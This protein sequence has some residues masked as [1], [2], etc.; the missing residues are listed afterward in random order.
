MKLFKT[1]VVV[2]L[3]AVMFSGAAFAQDAVG[4]STTISGSTTINVTDP[5]ITGG[6]ITGGS[7]IILPLYNPPVVRTWT[8]NILGTKYIYTYTTTTWANNN[9]LAQIAFSTK[10]YNRDNLLLGE[11]GY[12][13][14]FDNN[15]RPSQLFPFRRFADTYSYNAAKLLANKTHVY[16]L[17]NSRNRL[18]ETQDTRY[19]Y[20]YNTDNSI[21]EEVCIYKRTGSNGA[22]LDSWRSVTAYTYCANGD[23]Y[24]VY[25]FY[26]SDGKL[27][28]KMADI[29][30]ADGSGISKYKLFYDVDANGQ[31]TYTHVFADTA[32]PIVIMPNQPSPNEIPGVGGA[33]EIDPSVAITGIRDAANQPDDIRIDVN[34]DLYINTDKVYD[35]SHM[36][37]NVSNNLNMQS[38]QQNGYDIYVNG[39]L[40]IESTG[41]L[42]LRGLKIYATG[43]ITI[44]TAEDITVDSDSVLAAGG[45]ILFNAGGS[46]VTNGV[47]NPAA[48]FVMNSNVSATVNT[49]TGR[50]V[51]GDAGLAERLTVQQGSIPLPQ[52]VTISG[53]IV[54]SGCTLNMAKKIE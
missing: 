7:I 10:R 48:Q 37:I 26:G 43:N 40:A 39:D 35:F 3:L 32:D 27:R 15:G 42:D 33:G 14:N 54:T 22:L 6:S 29:S 50:I 31:V 36:T 24:S 23:S 38:G 8:I 21:K 5:V 2:F 17:Y 9:K 53:E 4:G 1:A 34:G 28:S 47:V 12:E 19:T 51:N 46:I 41:S 11:T 45:D 16:Y 44:T 18:V 20:T 25:S 49:T 52:G 13:Y 30:I